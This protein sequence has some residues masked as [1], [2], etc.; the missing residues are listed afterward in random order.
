M[1]DICRWAA[2]TNVFTIHTED[3][4]LAAAN[5]AKS[6]LELD[7]RVA[8]ALEDPWAGPGVYRVLVLDEREDSRVTT[9]FRFVSISN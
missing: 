2:T 6:I 1:Y 9:T 4:W 5:S 7:G 3:E 8:R